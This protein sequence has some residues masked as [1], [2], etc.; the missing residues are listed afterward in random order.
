MNKFPLNE[1]SRALLIMYNNLD[2]KCKYPN[3]KTIKKIVDIEKHEQ[4]CQ[5]KKCINYDVCENFVRE[6]LI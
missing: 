4:T 6:V 1:I 3:C 5:A 2:I